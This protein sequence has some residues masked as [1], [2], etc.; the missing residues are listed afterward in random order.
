M[1]RCPSRQKRSDPGRSGSREQSKVAGGLK[2]S[3]R[4]FA[5]LK[6]V[7]LLMV[8]ASRVSGVVRNQAG[9][10]MECENEF[11]RGCSC[12]RQRVCALSGNL[13]VGP[14]FSTQVASL[15]AK[16]TALRHECIRLKR[17]MA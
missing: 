5:V 12:L 1:S 15:F 11:S 10:T 14:C 17:R 6:A 16:V 4:S 9:E 3:S 2:R 7:I 13:S 8:L